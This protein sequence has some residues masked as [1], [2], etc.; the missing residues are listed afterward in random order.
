MSP[1]T[2]RRHYTQTLNVNVMFRDQ[3]FFQIYT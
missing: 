3:L 2:N 1:A